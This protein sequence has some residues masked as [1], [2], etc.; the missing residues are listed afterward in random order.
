VWDNFTAFLPDGLAIIIIQD[1]YFTNSRI[2]VGGS[3]FACSETS[4]RLSNVS[5]VNI[6]STNGQAAIFSTSD[7]SPWLQIKNCSFYLNDPYISVASFLFP[8]VAM[9]YGPYGVIENSAFI[10]LGDQFNVPLLE[11][12]TQLNTFNLEVTS[13][14]IIGFTS[15][16]G[17]ALLPISAT[18]SIKFANLIFQDIAFVKSGLIDMYPS[19]ASS[20]MIFSNCMFKNISSTSKSFPAIGQVT[21]LGQAVFQNCA[22]DNA[23]SSYWVINSSLP[24]PISFSSTV[25]SQICSLEEKQF[26]LSALTLLWLLTRIAV[27][28]ISLVL[29]CFT[30]SCS[31]RYSFKMLSSTIQGFLF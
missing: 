2:S 3:M 24:I 5:F 26:L 6:S 10:W 23:A 21:A 1:S 25:L 18:G 4:I 17:S 19:I 22:F 28:R 20:H 11:L 27:F 16:S 29:R 12:S 7:R 13:C 8:A 9:Y 15:N 31:R 30:A 14:S